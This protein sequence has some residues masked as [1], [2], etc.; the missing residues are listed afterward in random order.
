MAVLGW[1]SLGVGTALFAP[2]FRGVDEGRRALA[3]CSACA[4]VGALLA[5][6][7]AVAAGVGPIGDFFHTGTWLIA[8][9]G[10]VLALFIHELARTSRGRQNA[11]DPEAQDWAPRRAGGTSDTLDRNW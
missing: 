11:S 9:G 4:F 10:A 1:T 3:L 7:A 8:L 6:L 2:G 5:G